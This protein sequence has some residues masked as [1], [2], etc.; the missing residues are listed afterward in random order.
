MGEKR[1]EKRRRTRRQRDVPK[2]LSSFMVFLC[3]T[4]IQRCLGAFHDR[5]FGIM[6]THPA[7]ELVITELNEFRWSLVLVTGNA[8]VAS[9]YSLFPKW[10]IFRSLVALSEHM[11]QKIAVPLVGIEFF[12]VMYNVR[13]W[14]PL[15]KFILAILLL[16]CMDFFFNVRHLG[17]VLPLLGVLP[18]ILATVQNCLTVDVFLPSLLSTCNIIIS[19]ILSHKV[20]DKRNLKFDVMGDGEYILKIKVRHW[21]NIVRLLGMFC[22]MVCLCNLLLIKPPVES[23]EPSAPI[24]FTSYFSLHQNWP[25]QSVLDEFYVAT[26][27]NLSDIEVWDI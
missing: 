15:S 18:V 6:S 5:R 26:T 12:L 24:P 2:S 13:G 21:L 3:G 10:N 22:N 27:K 23:I 16:F 4:Y 7:P 25:L 17:R 19:P 9:L 14:F 20:M 8:L 1:G 11:T